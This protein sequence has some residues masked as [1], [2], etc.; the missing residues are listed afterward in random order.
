M[1]LNIWAEPDISRY[2]ANS[3]RTWKFIAPVHISCF[4]YQ[5]NSHQWSVWLCLSCTAMHCLK[6]HVTVHIIQQLCYSMLLLLAH[7]KKNT[8]NIKIKISTLNFSLCPPNLM[9]Q[10]H[11]SG[12]GLPKDGSWQSLVPGGCAKKGPDRVALTL[13]ALIFSPVFG[14]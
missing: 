7:D 8:Y 12:L 3:N 1:F 9:F 14:Y 10:S 6:W 5:W 11:L 4:T 13:S 2:N